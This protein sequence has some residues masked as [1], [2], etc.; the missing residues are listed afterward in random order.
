[1]DDESARQRV[2]ETTR[3]TSRPCCARR[4]TL[5]RVGTERLTG[6]QALVRSLVGE[7]VEAI[8]GL[9]G[10]QLDWLFDALYDVR[11]Q[12]GVYHTRHEQAAAYMADGYAR[13][14]GQVGVCTVVPGPGLLNAAAALATAY[15]CSSKVLCVTGQVDSRAIDQGFGLLH[16]IPHQDAVL[17]AF[18]K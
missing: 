16:E 10:V 11:D 5:R 17:T 18:T 9:P 7:G 12:L 13:T 2:S 1:R 14:T 4:G 15:A 6:G 3:R 8:F